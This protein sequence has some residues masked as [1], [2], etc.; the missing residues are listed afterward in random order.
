MTTT[1]E[2]TRLT[3]CAELNAEAGQWDEAGASLVLAGL[4]RAAHFEQ[5]HALPG[6]PL[7]QMCFCSAEMEDA[8]SPIARAVTTILP[9]LEYESDGPWFC[10][11]GVPGTRSIWLTR[12]VLKRVRTALGMTR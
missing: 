3:L 5:L 7:A 12:D 6:I 8:L 2:E 9:D 11:R 1:D 4:E 10:T